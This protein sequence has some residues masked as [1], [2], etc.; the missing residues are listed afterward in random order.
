MQMCK[1]AP[2]TVVG[3][4]KVINLNAFN[5]ILDFKWI[6]SIE[7]DK[8]ENAVTLSLTTPKSIFTRVEIKCGLSGNNED[9]PTKNMVKFHYY[10]SK[11]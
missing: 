1:I 9:C 7:T 10:L 8:S 5:Y 6:P 3:N 11:L 2:K 4:H